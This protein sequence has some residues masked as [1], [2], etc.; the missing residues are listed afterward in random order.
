M[1]F[2]NSG[3]LVLFPCSERHSDLELEEWLTSAGEGRIPC[4]VTVSGLLHL[5]AALLFLVVAV[6]LL[7]GASLTLA[8]ALALVSLALGLWAI[9][10]GPWRI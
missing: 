1:F 8:T 3:F 5:A 2:A 7:I 9:A 10:T 6:V 4:T